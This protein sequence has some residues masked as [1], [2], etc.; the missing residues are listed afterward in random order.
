MSSERFAFCFLVIISPFESIFSGAGNLN[1][2][3][4]LVV[5]EA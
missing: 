4:V 5:D 1:T 3:P 2:T